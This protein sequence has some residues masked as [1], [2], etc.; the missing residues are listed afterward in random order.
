M[1]IDGHPFLGVHM[2]EFQLANGKTKV[3]TSTKAKEDGSVNPKV[4]ISANEYKEVRQQHDRQKGRYEQ[5]K[6][7]RTGPMRP[8]VTSRILLKKWQC[9]KEKDYQCGLEEEERECRCE[10]ER[11]EREQ[12][13]LHWN[14]SF[15][16]HCWNE[17]LKLPIR[18]NCPEYSNQYQEF[19]QPQ[20]NRWSI[21]EHLNYQSNDM[22][23]HVKNEGV[24]DQLD[25]RVCDQNWA[26]RDEGEK[27]YVWQEGQVQEV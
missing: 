1:D 6:T 16:R 19:R 23:Q 18:C 12:V 4:Q 25:K 2:V 10:E 26:D 5:G 27:E 15:F 17:G 20:A 24:Y 13:E 21:H 9:Q 14:C 11:Y 8:H 22:D 3:L 7:S